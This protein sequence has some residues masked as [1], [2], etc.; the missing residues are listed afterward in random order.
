M[1][2]PSSISE[3]KLRIVLDAFSRWYKVDAKEM[4]YAN[5]QRQ[6]AEDLKKGRKHRYGKEGGKG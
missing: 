6:K 1:E 5:D 4:N 2:N 3:D